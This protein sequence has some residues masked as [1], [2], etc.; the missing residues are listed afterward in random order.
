MEASTPCI[1][2]V[3][4]PASRVMGYIKLNSEILEITNLKKN[5]YENL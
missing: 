2:N 1:N 3:L 5:F 4:I